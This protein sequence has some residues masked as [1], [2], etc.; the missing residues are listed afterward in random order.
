MSEVIRFPWE[1]EIQDER[2]L[3]PF[4]E[5]VEKLEDLCGVQIRGI[6]AYRE[7]VAPD[8]T[9]NVKVLAEI[10]SFAG[11]GHVPDG[12]I[13]VQCAAYDSAGRVVDV[14]TE[15]LWEGKYRGLHALSMILQC[16]AEP[17]RFVIFPRK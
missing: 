16:R 3:T 15:Y 11:I 5:R 17:V 13:Q 8:G 12:N 9:I 10:A 2:D 14:A 1:P 7:S 6:S 4:V